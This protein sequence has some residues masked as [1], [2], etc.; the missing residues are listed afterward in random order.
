MNTYLCRYCR[1]PSDPNS[2]ICPL[3]GAPVDIRS[4]VSD[5]GWVEQPPVKDMAHLQFGRSHVQIAGTTV[6]VA[7]FNLASEDWIYFC[8]HT[9]LWTDP[10][11][12]LTNMP[13]R[14]A[15]NRTMA[16]LP[17]IMLQGQGPGHI[18]L[19]D[20]SAGEIVALPLQH[21][22]QMWIREHRFLA[23]TGNI[24]YEWYPTDVWYQTGSGDDRETHYP[25][26]RYG[27]VFG[28]YRG[29]G[30]VL[31]HSP[32]N[33]FVRDLQPGQSLLVQPSS[34]LYR[35]LSVRMALHLEYPRNKGIASW[36]GQWSYRCVWLRL[37]GPGRVAV[38]S[39]YE[40]PQD[41]EMITNHSYATTHHW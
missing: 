12:R 32:G 21:G 28:A 27:D 14:G 16:G 41:T 39:S 26:G 9:L 38:Q 30:L 17:L 8:H 4:S 19:S 5:S 25:M 15:W 29:P 20:N 7:E 18:A 31:L 6:P 36:R 34:L 37:F 23:A 1:Q 2:P 13:M 10:V 35:D 40:P 33:A 3:C 24:G 11:T 22:Q